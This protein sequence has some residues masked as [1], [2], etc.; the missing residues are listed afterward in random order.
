M[1]PRTV[2][3]AKTSCKTGKCR[4]VVCMTGEG[5]FTSEL[6]VPLNLP[7][8]EPCLFPPNKLILLTGEAS[9]HKKQAE[10]LTLHTSRE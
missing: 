9:Y 7:A 3:V 8:S 1:V 10:P 6:S 5:L 4:Q 2:S